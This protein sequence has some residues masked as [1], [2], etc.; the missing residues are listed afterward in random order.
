[1]FLTREKI[2]NFSDI[3]TT[4]VSVPE[5]GG[6][7]MV[8]GMTGFQRDQYEGALYNDGNRNFSNVRAK[9]VALSIVDPE[10]KAPMF[11]AGDIE[12]LGNKSA[13]ALDRV[14]SV[15]QKLSGLTRDD[16]DDL[17]KNSQTDL[18]DISTTN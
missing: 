10:T 3:K 4:V 13:A 6:D 11:T 8:R 1:M 14:F 12:V 15:A 2:L 18:S 5:W 9:L 7:V 17:S 16:V